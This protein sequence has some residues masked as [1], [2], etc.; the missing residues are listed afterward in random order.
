MLHDDCL[1]CSLQDSDPGA[2]VFLDDLWAAEVAPGF[3]V[4]GWFFLRARRHADA[5]SGLTDE[6]AE[7]LGSRARDLARAVEQVTEAPAVYLLHFG[8]N[9]RHFHALVAARG[10]DV[11]KG[12]RGG[13]VL[14]LVADRRDPVAAAQV[15]DRVRRAYAEMSDVAQMGAGGAARTEAHRS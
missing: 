6:E 3:E 13:A 4:P 12:L 11:P 2:R 15:A 1:I 9:H 5:L 10:E 14:Q 7:T 8:E